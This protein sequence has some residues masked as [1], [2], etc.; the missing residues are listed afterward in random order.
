MLDLDGLGLIGWCVASYRALWWLLPGAVGAACGGSTP[1]LQT[2]DPGVVF[3]YP[4]DQQLDVPLGTR[5]V[6]TFSEKVSENALGACTDTSGAFCLVGPNGVVQATP[7]VTGDGFSVQFADAQLEP[8]TPYQVFVR[9]ELDPAASNLPASGPL[10]QFTTRAQRPRSAAPTLIAVNGAPVT[11]PEAFRPMLETST[12]RLVFSEPLDPKTTQLA[13]GAIELVDSTGAAVPA[14]LLAK[15]IHVAIDPIDDLTPGE[16]YQV[17]LGNQLLDLGGQPVAPTTVSL[18]PQN[19]GAAQPIRQVL[20]TRQPTDP[21][22]ARSR[23]GADRNVIAIDKP[24]IGKETSTVEPATLHAELGQPDALGGPIAFTIRRGERLKASGLDVKL[25]GQIDAGVHTGDIII[26]FLTDAGGRLY[27]NPYQPD[28]QRPENDRAPLYVDLSMDVAVYAVDPTGNAVLSQVALGLQA[29]GTAVATDGVLAI[30]S[31][32]S[33]ELGLLGVTAAPSNLVLE[34]ITDESATVPADTTPPTLV[35]TYPGEGTNEASVGAG[36]EL[37]FSEPPDLDRL[38]ANGI[39][40][41]TLGGQTIPT[42]IESHGATIVLRPRTPLAYATTFDVVLDDVADVAGNVMAARPPIAFSTPQLA[43]TGVPITVTAVHPGVA[44]ALTGGNGTTPGRCAGGNNNDD[45]YQP[46]ALAA[47]EPVE[48]EF[49]QPIRQNTVVLGTACGSGDVRI[50][51]LDG[52]GNC[53]AAVPG[54]LIHRERGM[55]FVPDAPWTEGTRYRLAAISID[56]NSD[57]DAGELCGSNNNAASYDPLNGGG[58]GGGPTLSIDFVGAPASKATYLLSD[59]GPFSD[60]NG[61]FQVNNVEIPRDDNRAALRITSTTSDIKSASF[62]GTDCVPGTP[63]KEACMYLTGAMAVELGEVTNECPL[64]FG[65]TASACVPVTVA[66]GVMYATSVNMTATI[67]AILV[68]ISIDSDTGITVMRVREPSGGPI[69]GYMID[70][71]GTPKMVVALDLYMD[72]PDLSLPLSSHDLHSKPISVQLEGPV[73]FL[74][75]GRISI[76]LSNVADVPV[77]INVSAPLGVGG[78]VNLLLP[79]G[80]MKLQLLSRPLRGA[81]P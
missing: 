24:L 31:V 28:E 20:R 2:A 38:R 32:S 51:Q 71:G 77:A 10:F 56:N 19:S 59:A 30:E 65:G 42:V 73:T 7:E 80:E 23:S 37:V 63:E 58:S 55:Q 27:R 66:P 5:I 15:D 6:V 43:N 34:L 21:G 44:C 14:T 41:E 26:E 36:V 33:M 75:D 40:L 35:A 12:I 16:T 46:F 68:N 54:T 9:S 61:D 11:T 39:H 1:P 69:T 50:E 76:A 25:G 8:G 22:P 60:I 29:S 45:T 52:G 67:N 62:G 72:A 70:G 49:S 64:P 17:K 13:T 47:N 3:V 57:C 81:E 48:L 79:A 74:P 4:A 53:V 78:A 18:T